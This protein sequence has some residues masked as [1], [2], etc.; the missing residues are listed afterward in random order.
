VFADEREP[1]SWPY[2]GFYLE[3][4]DAHGAWVASAIDLVRF[5]STLD[6][7]R[8][9]GLLK[10]E[11]VR[12]IESRPPAPM[13]ADAPAYYGLGWNVRPEGKGANWW[14]NGSLP[15]TMSLLVRTH[16]GFAWAAVFNMRPKDDGK[17]L[18]E[19]DG[20][21]WKAVGRVRKWPK[22][23]LLTHD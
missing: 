22:D 7:S 3:A 10:P 1:V 12:R 19:L 18:G 8:K 5:A 15:G 11:T 16:H 23:D 20:A 21:I 9:P 2:G 14:H 4:M 6:G 13:A 17:F